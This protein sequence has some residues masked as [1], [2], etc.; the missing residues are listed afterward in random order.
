MAELAGLDPKTKGEADATYLLAKANGDSL[1]IALTQYAHEVWT[2][3]AT[4]VLGN[5][6]FFA[7][8]SEDVEA[9]TDS[10]FYHIRVGYRVSI[11]APGAKKGETWHINS[12][13]GFSPHDLSCTPRRE[14]GSL[15]NRS[16]VKAFSD[17]V[18]TMGTGLFNICGAF[19]RHARP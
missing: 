10:A 14:G 7:K 13:W 12:I 3:G 1:G 2:K 5:K 15:G 11:S 18:A 16:L 8:V 6:D 4:G 19:L 9:D 17:T